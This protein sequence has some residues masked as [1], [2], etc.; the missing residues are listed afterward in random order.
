MKKCSAN[1]TD[2]EARK[3]KILPALREIRKTVTS[4]SLVNFCTVAS[5]AAGVIVP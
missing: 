5:R 4:G 1:H 2:F 3:G